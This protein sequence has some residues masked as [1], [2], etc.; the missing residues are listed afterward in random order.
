MVTTED[1]G[2]VTVDGKDIEVTTEDIGEVTVDGKDIEVTTEDIGEVTVDGKDIEVTT[3]DIGEVTVDGKDIEV[4]SS[5][6]IC[7]LGRADYQGWTTREGNA[8][9][10]SY[11]WEKPQWGD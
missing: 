9:K 3:E 6:N 10:N 8:K 4:Q 2:E 1:I 11:M 7:F 5:N